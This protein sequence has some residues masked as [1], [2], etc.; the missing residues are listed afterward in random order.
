MCPSGD[1]GI[2]VVNEKFYNYQRNIQIIY[3]SFIRKEMK[4][5]I[6]VVTTSVQRRLQIFRKLIDVVDRII[7]HFINGL[8]YSHNDNIS[9]QFK[10][11][12]IN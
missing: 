3:S 6:Y 5:T 11:I 7:L 10:I 2:S 9:T 1:G 4:K 12:S 8:F